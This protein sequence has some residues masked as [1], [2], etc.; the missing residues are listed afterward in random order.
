MKKTL[1]FCASLL[2]S[3]LLPAAVCAANE[4]STISCKKIAASKGVVLLIH[5]LNQSVS[6]LQEFENYFAKKKFSRCF[7]RLSGSNGRRNEPSVTN[8]EHDLL[9]AHRLLEQHFP[10]QSQYGFGYSIG[11]TLLVDAIDR[12][13]FPRMSRLILIAPAFS[14]RWKSMLLRMILPLRHLGVSLP[15]ASPRQYRDLDSL[16]LDAYNS[17]LTFVDRIKNL[18]NPE[19]LRSRMAAV[20]LHNDDEIVDP[21]GTRDWIQDKRL[22]HWSIHMLV[23]DNV[24]DDI[25]SHLMTD[26]R[27]VGT[28]TWQTLLHAFDRLITLPFTAPLPPTT[29]KKD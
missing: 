24:A 9:I 13:L 8:W 10:G 7:L 1:C 15:S 5:G 3:I 2:L 22:A 27:T 6:A 21:A 28:H 19:R 18:E 16:S 20:F 12:G 17:S 29:P 14:L 25:P 23:K 4:A 26:E 11:G